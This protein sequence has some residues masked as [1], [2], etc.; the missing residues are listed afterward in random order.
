MTTIQTVPF[1]EGRAVESYLNWKCKDKDKEVNEIVAWLPGRRDSQIRVAVKWNHL[2]PEGNSGGDSN[3]REGAPVGDL[4]ISPRTAGVL[5]NQ[6][7]ETVGALPASQND[8][9]EIDG[10]GP[11]T[12]EEILEALDG[13]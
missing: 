3:T 1:K 2:E 11:A 13:G 12:A 4:D 7:Y 9:E 6:G 5:R 10:V 8:L